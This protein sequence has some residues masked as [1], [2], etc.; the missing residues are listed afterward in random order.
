MLSNER[1]SVTLLTLGTMLAVVVLMMIVAHFYSGFIGAREAQNA[2]DSAS[3][4]AIEELRGHF[5]DTMVEDVDEEI[6]SFVAYVC[7]EADDD[8]DDNDDDDNGDDNSNGNGD[9]GNGEGVCDDVDDALNDYLDNYAFNSE[10]MD[11]L[12]DDEFDAEEDWL[13]VLEEDYF[14]DEFISGFDDDFQGAFDESANGER[15]MQTFNQHEGDIVGAAAEFME[16]NEGNAD[17]D[18]RFPVDGEPTLEIDGERNIE[19]DTVVQSEGDIAARSAASIDPDF[20]ID[21]SLE[22]TRTVGP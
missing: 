19:V 17:F 20:D 8:D 5:E 9:N 6:D 16:R 4:A 2:V 10:L 22:Q 15:L 13:L 3:M 1:G 12:V 21:V 18:M 14:T 11:L 7:D